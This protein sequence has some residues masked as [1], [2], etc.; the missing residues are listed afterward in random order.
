MKTIIHEPKIDE[1]IDSINEFKKTGDISKLKDIQESISY[2]YDK[3]NPLD[4]K[5]DLGD[6][7]IK[8]N[9]VPNLNIEN[10]KIELEVN[11]NIKNDNVELF[12]KINGIAEN[13]I[14]PL[15]SE[16]F[17]AQIGAKIKC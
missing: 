1:L 9:I 11:K 3:Y 12:F 14:S 2:L 5:I 6:V 8:W 17:K 4:N 15:N 10:T 16:G 7:K 13:F